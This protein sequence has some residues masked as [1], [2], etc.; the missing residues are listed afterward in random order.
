[1]KSSE[2]RIWKIGTVVGFVVVIAGLLMTSPLN[3]DDVVISAL[4]GGTAIIKGLYELYMCRIAHR[5]T[6][7]WPVYISAAVVLNLV[8]G[9]QLLLP[10]Y[11]SFTLFVYVFTMLYIVG[12]SA[13][14]ALICH[15]RKIDRDSDSY[16]SLL[17]LSGF[18]LA[19]CVLLPF[20]P[21]FSDYLTKWLVAV[22]LI[23]AGLV[24]VISSKY[25]EKGE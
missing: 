16:V 6:G 23:V 1:M 24:Q 19:I 20:G 25:L 10:P 2:K 14:M 5:M 11:P 15:F 3:E 13:N 9:S 8:V 17:G 22:Y 12:I 7:R 21:V 4:T 18:A